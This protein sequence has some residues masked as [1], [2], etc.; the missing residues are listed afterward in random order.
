MPAKLERCVQEV[1]K[2]GKSKESAY[3][4]C[5]ASL[6]GLISDS[7]IGIKATI[8]EVSGFLTAP[9]TLARVGIQDYYGFELGLEN[10]SSEKIRVYRPPTEVFADASIKSFINLVLTDDHPS[11]PVTIDNV[12]VLQV[13][14]VSGVEPN[15]EN[16]TLNG[17]LTITK[18]NM[19]D[20]INGGK[21]EVSVGYSHDLKEEKGI[22]NGI[23]YDYVQTN[24]RANHLAIVDAGRCG[25]ACRITLDKESPVEKVTI[26]G[27]EYDVENPQLAQAIRKNQKAHDAEVDR[28]IKDK[29][30]S[31][32]EKEEMEK[33]KDEAEAAKDSLLAD[34][35][36]FSDDA[37]AKMVTD[38][39][40]LLTTAKKILGDEM[41][42]CLTCDKEIKAAVIDKI[43]GLDVSGKSVEYINAAY[44][45][46]IINYE[47]NKKSVDNLN[48]D[49]QKDS[50]KMK[51]REEIQKKYVADH[52][53]GGK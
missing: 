39:A 4:I 51:S 19:I 45:M 22:Y 17:I 34:S 2:Q 35:S 20:K 40:L 46:A 32:E 41:P 44:D 8:D 12:D 38:K 16:G 33:K 29:M 15:K 52:L 50:T 36:K 48:K 7:K 30:K 6:D 28:L 1:M 49:F 27:I 3:A 18:K 23:E 5:T 43:N 13:G 10:R 47:K 14:T 42:E 11:T 24:I 53:N 21:L 26:D 31:D 25:S 37:I 9:V